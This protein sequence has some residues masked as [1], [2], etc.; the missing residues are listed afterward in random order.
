M[1]PSWSCNSWPGSI[2]RAGRK[3]TS[4]RAMERHPGWKPPLEKGSYESVAPQGVGIWG[5]RGPTAATE[6]LQRWLRSRVVWVVR[7]SQP[8]PSTVAVRGRLGQLTLT[9]APLRPP[10]VAVRGPG[11]VGRPLCDSSGLRSSSWRPCDLALMS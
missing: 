8:G 1:G 11:G 4:G 10:G 7:P 2:S 5:G 9:A 3:A 6:C